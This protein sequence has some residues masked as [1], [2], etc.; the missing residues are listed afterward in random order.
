M[1]RLIFPAVILIF[2]LS[3]CGSASDG[4]HKSLADKE[5]INQSNS[6]EEGYCSISVRVAERSRYRNLIIE[7]K[8]CDHDTTEIVMKTLAES[9]SARPF[10]EIDSIIWQLPENPELRR[11]LLI[12]WNEACKGMHLSQGE[13]LANNRIYS[14]FTSLLS[15]SSAAKTI[16]ELFPASTEISIGVESFYPTITPEDCAAGL[17][18]MPVLSFNLMNENSVR[19]N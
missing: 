19:D 16:G 17:N 5:S 13:A 7:S 12:Y 2:V 18:T 9:I 11:E 14:K 8:E 1:S 15:E 4:I 10:G 6:G 3:A